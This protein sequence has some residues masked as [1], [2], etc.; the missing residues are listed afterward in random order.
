MER[1]FRNIVVLLFLILAVANHSLLSQ[2]LL[3]VKNPVD[4][5]GNVSVYVKGSVL[6]SAGT[7]SEIS[8]DGIIKLTGNWTNNVASSFLNGTGEVVF[9]G[10]SGNQQI[11]GTQTTRFYKLTIDNIHDVV[12]EQD[13]FVDDALSLTNGDLDLNNSTAN[14]G[15]TGMISGESESSRVKLGDI[16]NNTGTIQA[17]RDINNAANYDPANLGV[18]ITSDANLGNVTIIR[19]HQLQNGTGTFTGNTSIARYI[20]LRNAS[21]ELIDFEVNAANS[22][23]LNYWDAELN[24][25]NET[26]LSQYQWVSE[27]AESWWTPLLGTINAS[28]NVSTPDNNPYSDYFEEPNWYTL[29]FEGKYTLASKDNPLPVEWLSFSANWHDETYSMVD[30]QWETASETNADYFEV[31]R[32]EDMSSWEYINTVEANGSSNQTSQYACFDNNPPNETETIYYR[33]KQVDN[34]GAYEYSK[35]AALTVPNELDDNISLF[36]NPAD[37]A[38]NLQFISGVDTPIT[39]YIWDELGKNVISREIEIVAGLNLIRFD[40]S[41][42]A[43]AVYTMQIITMGGNKKIYRQFIINK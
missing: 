12:L 37:D 1:C 14:L 6:G 17:T 33:L 24:G 27:S 8:N 13:I 21:D 18:L 22:V 25:Q 42:L 40:I 32:S 19:G 2:N 39:V 35:V 9:N 36:P 29:G 38:I 10:S 30:I 28:S 11:E 3:T 41:R 7:G 4:I 5:K 16:V 15:A 34:D 31:Q 26:I 20:E 43:P 23:R